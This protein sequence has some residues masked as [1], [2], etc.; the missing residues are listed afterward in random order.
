MILCT[1]IPVGWST[2][3]TQNYSHMIQCICRMW[4]CQRQ[5]LCF[6]DMSIPSSSPNVRSAR[7]SLLTD[8]KH[9]VSDYGYWLF[10]GWCQILI[11]KGPSH[12]EY[13]D[14][15]GFKERNYLTFCQLHYAL[16]EHPL[17]LGYGWEVFVR[18]TLPALP[19]QLTPCNSS[20]D[21]EDTDTDDE[22]SQCGESTDSDEE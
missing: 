16:L 13:K 1:T 5:G 6:L 21:T 3:A 2:S 12:D 10:S 9:I 15:I 19:K 7:C 8:Y 18:H 11:H 14:K 20:D 4:V 22:W 17:P